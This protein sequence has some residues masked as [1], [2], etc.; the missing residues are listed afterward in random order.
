MRRNCLLKNA[1]EG[2][3][4]RRTGATGRR[5]RRHKQLLVDLKEESIL[6]TARGKL[7]RYLRTTRCGA[8][9]DL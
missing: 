4:E 1:T 5:V 8:A 7:D 2:K 6:E 9:V 3:I